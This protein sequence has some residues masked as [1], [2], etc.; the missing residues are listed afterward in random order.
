MTNANSASNHKILHSQQS[1][2][3]SNDGT[4]IVMV[5][6][7]GALSSYMNLVRNGG[8]YMDLV[9]NHG[10]YMTLARNSSAYMHGSQ[11]ILTLQ[12]NSE[13]FIQSKH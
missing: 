9:T 4:Y 12:M 5:R 10:A 2:Q 8:A 1:G 7:C 13:Y 11:C 6:N 3:I